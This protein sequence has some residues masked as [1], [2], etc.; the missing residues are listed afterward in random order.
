MRNSFKILLGGLVTA[1]SLAFVAGWEGHEPKPYKDIAGVLTVCNGYTGA[2][3]D[4]NKIYGKA[5]CD[6]LLIKELTIHG[7]AVLACVHVPLNQNQ[8]N[9]LV[10]L[11]YNVGAGAVCRSGLP[12]NKHL[13]DLFNDGNYE[14]G[15]NRIMAYNKARVNGKLVVVRGLTNRRTA[16]RNMC[17]TPISPATGGQSYA[18]ASG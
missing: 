17:L 6:A 2:D 11:A 1:S 4:P 18:T 10:S 16:E 7:K 15:C 12:K 8:Y 13:I 14:A 3:I 9:A 5:E